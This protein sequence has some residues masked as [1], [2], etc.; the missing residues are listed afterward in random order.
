M[1][2]AGIHIK[3]SMILMDLLGPSILSTLWM[4]G[5]VL[6]RERVHLKVPEWSLVWNEL[7]TKKLSV[8]LSRLNEIASFWIVLKFL[9]MIDLTT[10]YKWL[11]RKTLTAFDSLSHFTLT[12]PQLNLSFLKTLNYNIARVLALYK[13]YWAAMNKIFIYARPCV[14]KMTWAFFSPGL[15]VSVLLSCSAVFL[16]FEIW[17]KPAKNCPIFLS[18]LTF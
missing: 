14:N 12:T 13:S 5:Q 11:R 7:L 4:K 17:K 18:A 2:L 1:T 8:F 15:R 10:N 16:H 3:W 9:R 6:Q